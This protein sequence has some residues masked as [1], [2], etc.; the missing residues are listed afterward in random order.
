[1]GKQSGKNKKQAAGQA[2]A[3]DSNLKLNSPKANDKD[4]AVLI[5]M[6]Q[7]LKEE[8]NRLFQKRNHEGAMMKYEKAIK[9]LPRNH[10]D[11]SYLRSNMAAC[12]MQMG[13]NEYP[14]AIHECNLALEVTPKYGKALL[15]RARCYEAL[16]RLDLALKDVTMVL[17]MEP[18]NVMA[19]EIAERVKQALEQKGLRVNDTT[20]DKVV[21]EKQIS[22]AKEEPK[23]TVKLI[24]GEDIRWAQL[25]LNCSL[26]QVREVISDRFPG[27]GPVLIKYRDQEGDLVTITTDEELRWAEA[28][29]ES[30]ASIRL[31]LVKVNPQQCLFFGKLN[32]EELHEMGLEKKFS[33][34][35]G[36]MEKGKETEN[37][38]C[39]IDEWILEFAKLF[40]EHGGLMLMHTLSS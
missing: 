23:K 16:N 4:A 8:G 11:V 33:R 7:E 34:V 21:I 15:K 13:L 26:L 18:N 30:Q 28:S 5:S 38:S 6:S 29:A 2:D 24:F 20:E 35:N 25:P 19:I 40:K 37:G 32:N 14:R 9:L 3:V 36:N 10:I 17:K 1:M 12:Y 31:Y 27:S 22:G 39:H